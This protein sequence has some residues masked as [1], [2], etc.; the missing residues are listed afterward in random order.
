MPSFRLSSFMT[1]RDV[2]KIHQ[3]ASWLLEHS[4]SDGQRQ[5]LQSYSQF[6]AENMMKP[7]QFI[8]DQIGPNNRVKSGQFVKT[9]KQEDQISGPIVSGENW[10]K[11]LRGSSTNKLTENQIM[12]KKQCFDVSKNHLERKAK[13]DKVVWKGKNNLEDNK[14]SSVKD[15]ELDEQI[16]R[17]GIRQFAP[18]AFR[19]FALKKAASRIADSNDQLHRDNAIAVTLFMLSSTV[20]LIQLETEQSS[21]VFGNVSVEAKVLRQI[22]GACLGRVLSHALRVVDSYEGSFMILLPLARFMLKHANQLAS[23]SEVHPISSGTLNLLKVLVQQQKLL[24]QLIQR[25]EV[26]ESPGALAVQILKALSQNLRQ[27][28][29]TYED[30]ALASLFMINNLQ[31]IGQTVSR[32]RTLLALLQGDQTA[33]PSSFETEAESYLQQFLKVWSKVGEVFNADLGP[34]EEKRSVKSIFTVFTREFDAIV[35]QQKIYCVADQITAN[36]V[37]MRIKSLVL[38]PFVEFSKKNSQECSELF[39][40]DRQLKYDAETIEMIIDRLFDATL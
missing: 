8:A 2:Q 10:R 34:G 31:Y 32:E 35:E 25:A 39:E 33:F 23:L 17:I 7:L 11:V 1:L 19:L 9:H 30:P 38:Q 28:S 29:S 24:N 37:R 22:V 6:R 14:V 16:D 21:A 5:F 13:I 40:A 3:I 36:N 20:V 4:D 18:I 15:K 27:K 26:H 12:V